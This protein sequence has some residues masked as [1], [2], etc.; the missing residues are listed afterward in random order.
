MLVSFG[1]PMLDALVL[2]LTI[3]HAVN[4]T[5]MIRFWRAELT[6]RDDP[7]DPLVYWER[8]KAPDFR[9]GNIRR[10]A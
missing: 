4:V 9:R 2:T 5:L 1:N 10:A 8:R 3:V 7:E 6:D